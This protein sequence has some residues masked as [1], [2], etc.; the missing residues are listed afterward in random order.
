MGGLPSRELV[1][2]GQAEEASA[3]KMPRQPARTTFTPVMMAPLW[4]VQPSEGRA[5][6]QNRYFPLGLGNLARHPPPACPMASPT[7][8]KAR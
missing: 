7:S 5:I 2:A 3:S 8:N 4:T 1:R 6:R